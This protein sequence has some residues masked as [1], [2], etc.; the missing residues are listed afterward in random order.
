MPST[1]PFA[2]PHGSIQIECMPFTSNSN[3][4]AKASR[5]LIFLQPMAS[6]LVFPVKKHVIRNTGTSFHHAGT[7]AA[8]PADSTILPNISAACFMPLPTFVSSSTLSSSVVQN[9][10]HR[11][12]EI[13]LFPAAPSS[14][15]ACV[16]GDRE[17][18]FLHPA[19]LG[20]GIAKPGARREDADPYVFSLLFVN[21]TPAVVAGL[22]RGETSA[23]P[24]PVAASS[25]RQA[26]AA[27]TC[28]RTGHR[29]RLQM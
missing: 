6:Q 12:Q 1:G 20:C 13:S 27:A 11:R 14:R 24:Q 26:G 15:L 22:P 23:P 2:D 17:L 4:G 16:N 3:F 7:S 21:I 9:N 25:H 28:C 8:I 18:L 29:P 19:D 5:A 10:G